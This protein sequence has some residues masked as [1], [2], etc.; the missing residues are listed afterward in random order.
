MLREIILTLFGLWLLVSLPLVVLGS[1]FGFRR[2]ASEPPVKI[3]KLCRYIPDQHWY[4]RPP[5]TYLVPGIIPFGA[6]FIELRFIFNSLWQGMVYYVFGFLALVFFIWVLTT[7]LTTIVIVYYQL[8]FEDWRWWWPSYF[9]PGG[10]GLHFFAYCVYYY[11]TQLNL[12]SGASSLLYFT[13]TGM[14]SIAYGV[15]VGTLGF[16]SAL[17]FVSRIYGALHID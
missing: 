4:L 5:F 15:M 14:A 6:A 1:S 7:A 9:V 12:Q 3:A 16:F 17:L 13:Y 11:G 10:C 8:C 2:P